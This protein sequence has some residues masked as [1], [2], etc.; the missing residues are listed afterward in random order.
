MVWDADKAAKILD[1]YDNCYMV[2]PS[3]GIKEL[4]KTH[5]YKV[6]L[7]SSGKHI[8]IARERNEGSVTAYVNSKSITGN[9]FQAGELPG[10]LVS[11]EYFPGHQGPT[12]D[13]GISGSVAELETLNPKYNHVYRLEVEGPSSFKD[14]LNWY[15]GLKDF[16]EI[17]VA[18]D[19]SIGVTALSDE[20]QKIALGI[21][22]KISDDTVADN[23]PDSEERAISGE[24]EPIV[25]AGDPQEALELSEMAKKIDDEFADLEGQDVDA[26]VKRRVGQGVFRKLLLE[27]F[28]GA[29]CMTGLAN[30]RLLIA[31]HIVPW[32]KSEPAQKLA[33]DNGLL[34]SASMDA[35]F[36]KGL[37]SFSDNGG[38]LIGDELDAETIGILGL[39][40]EFSLPE[41]V[42][43]KGRLKNLAKHREFHGFGSSI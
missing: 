7:G 6:G 43:T 42:L 18:N 11:G 1:D 9:S 15:R 30:L 13:K 28:G 2:K 23:A 26:I 27:Q 32:S 35:L 5:R 14:M 24:G 19:S 37:I 39:D 17:P 38:I 10:V 4:K 12:G 25:G 20:D 21:G 36:D 29:C 34:L 8:A 22:Q 33:S 16:K 40:K 3:S 41:A 31:S